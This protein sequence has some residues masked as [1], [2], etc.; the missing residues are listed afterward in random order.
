[1][2]LQLAESY[3]W[4]LICRKLCFLMANKVGIAVLLIILLQQTPTPA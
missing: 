1:M 4:I 2:D 3:P